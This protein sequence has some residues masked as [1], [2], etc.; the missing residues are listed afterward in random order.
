M[1]TVG[2]TGRITY[3]ATLEPVKL[4]GSTI[5]SATL[6]NAQY[7]IEKDIRIGDYVRIF[8]AAEIIPKV[9]EVV[10]N[11]RTSDLKPFTPI[12]HCPI[13]NSILEKQVD[14]VDQYCTN[15]SCKARI[16]QSMIHFCSKKAMNIEDLSDKN[17]EKLYEANIIT[18]IEDIYH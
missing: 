17:L 8:K 7:I 4:A 14:E 13:C 6:H 5:T 10:L 18:N 9:L 2:R 12:S 11:K 16:I 3:V 1:P 15:I